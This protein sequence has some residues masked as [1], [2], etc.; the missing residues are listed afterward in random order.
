MAAAR[1]ANTWSFEPPLFPAIN[2]SVQFAF[3]KKNKKTPKRYNNRWKTKLNK[4]SWLHSCVLR[5]VLLSSE[6]TWG[7]AATPGSLPSRCRPGTTPPNPHSL[8]QQQ[9]EEAR[10]PSA[11]GAEFIPPR[12]E[13][14]SNVWP[15]VKVF[16]LS[17]RGL[18]KPIKEVAGWFPGEGQ[19]KP[20]NSSRSLWK[21]YR[22]QGGR[23]GLV[24]VLFRKL[25]SQLH[26]G[27]FLMILD[28][29]GWWATSA[30]DQM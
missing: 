13:M 15:S 21:K 5:T 26:D 29:M 22:R 14:G 25:E 20:H 28:H 9:L 24:V 7:A 8:Q 12:W 18:M 2:S 4:C 23:S 11:G 10:D 19:K 16:G 17:G 30:N 6:A 27:I 1:D 3:S